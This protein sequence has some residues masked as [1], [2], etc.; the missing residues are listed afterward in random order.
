MSTTWVLGVYQNL[1][2]L[3]LLLSNIRERHDR[4]RGLSL[5]FKPRTGGGRLMTVTVQHLAPAYRVLRCAASLS[6]PGGEVHCLPPS[7]SP[8]LGL[9]S[10]QSCN[11]MALSASPLLP[12][13]AFSTRRVNS[14]LRD[15]FLW[16]LFSHSYFLDPTSDPTQHSSNPINPDISSWSGSFYCLPLLPPTWRDANRAVIFRLSCEKESPKEFLTQ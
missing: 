7:A 3:Q 14:L 13:F 11:L 10:S 12:F 8:A 2:R 9:P 15:L 6:P 5:T 4:T 16:L 1:L